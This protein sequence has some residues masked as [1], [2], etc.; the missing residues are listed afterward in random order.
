MLCYEGSPFGQASPIKH[1][2]LTTLAFTPQ[3][4]DSLS[5]LHIQFSLPLEVQPRGFILDTPYG[6]ESLHSADGSFTHKDPVIH[7]ALPNFAFKFYLRLKFL[8]HFGGFKREGRG[9][10]AVFL[11]PLKTMDSEPRPSL[12]LRAY[13]K[14]GVCAVNNGVLVGERPIG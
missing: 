13:C 12:F 7:G 1:G 8:F 2:L 5:P 10:E 14:I 11:S 3:P 4:R 6:C 9:S